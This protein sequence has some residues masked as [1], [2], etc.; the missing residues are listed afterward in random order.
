[1]PAAEKIDLFKEHKAEYTQAKKPT[2]IETGPASYIMIDGDGAPG[3]EEFEAAVALMMSVAYTMKF[4]SKK[5]G[6]DY[7]VCK[8]EGIWRVGSDPEAAL[9]DA[10]EQDWSW[11]LLIRTPEF[12]T[13]GDVDEAKQA[14]LQKT[15]DAAVASVRLE[16]LTEGRCVQMLHIGPYDAEQQTIDAIRKHCETEGVRMIGP[17]HEIYISDPRRVEPEMLKTII[18]YPVA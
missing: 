13:A 16:T 15:P 9:F 18:R 12:I 5:K 10:P 7:V 14:V 11:T 1:M 17:H 8:L 3:S 2:L 6:R 4:A